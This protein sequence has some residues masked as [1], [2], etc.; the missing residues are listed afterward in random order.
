M[1][2][3][4]SVLF[5]GIS[6]FAVIWLGSALVFGGPEG[7]TKIKIEHKNK[8]KVQVI[9]VDE[10][11]NRHEEVIE[12]DSD[13]PRAFL[14]VMVEK[15]TD[16]GALVEQVVEESGAERAGLQEGDVV[17]G[18]NGKEVDTPWDLTRGILEAQ[19][20]D[21]VDL[22][23]IRDG[24]RQSMTAELGEH[25]GWI[26]AFSGLE[27]LGESLGMLGEH[28]GKLDLDIVIPDIDIDI[29]D[30][31]LHGLNVPGLRHRMLIGSGHRPRLG[32]QLVQPTAELREHLGGSEDAGVVVGKVL[33]GTP[34]EDSDLRVGDMIVAAD[35]SSV[36]NASDLIRA[37]HGK[38]GETIQLDLI[39]D[40]RPMA[41]DVF[42]PEREEEEEQIRGPRA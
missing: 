40:G 29:P 32:V 22:E 2:L 38:D 37:L 13:N 7:D 23:V 26:G 3:R 31:K 10:D 36:E 28:L 15:A 42:I 19:P 1:K 24:N 33:P 4:N 5:G 30:L 25:E 20:G 21:T 18:I 9:V 41:L 6:A 35:G 11:G 39:R 17:V 12:F 34:A 16:G 8:G 27:G 14:G